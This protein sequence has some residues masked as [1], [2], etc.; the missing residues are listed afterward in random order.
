MAK[1]GTIRFRRDPS[2]QGDE[3]YHL[4]VTSAGIN[5]SASTDIGLFYGATT[6]WQLIAGSTDG[7]IGAVSIDDAPAFAWRGVMLDSARHFQP[8]AYIKQLIDRMAMDKLN[9]LHWH[10]TDDQAW[11]IPID[12]YPRLI[13]VGAWRQPAGAAGFDASGKPVRY[14]GFYT[15]AEIRDIVAYAA[16]RHITVVPE[17]EM[18]GHATAAI[19]AYPRLGSTATPPTTPTS[20]WGVMY[21]LYNTDDATFAFL[22]DVLD[23][24]LEL[25]PSRYI[26]VGGDEAVKDQWIADPRA[27]ARMKT[28]GITDY[29]QL[30]GWYIARIGD[31]LAKRGRKLVGWD[32]ILD[33]KVPPSATV[34]SWRGID[35]AIKAAKAGHDAILAPS[36]DFYIDHIQSESD[37][38]PPGR[39]GVMDWKHI[40]TFDVAPAALTAME[41]KY[42][43]GV[44]VNL[45]TEH[46]RTT[47][48]ADRML[49]PRAA[50]LAELG[51]TPTRRRD[52]S[53]FAA[54]LPAEFARY[55][56]LGFAYNMTPLEP[57]ASF[58]AEDGKL[59]VKLRQPAGVGMLRYTTDGTTPVATSPAYDG[60][61]T[62]NEGTKLRVRAFAGAAALG[63]GRDWTMATALIRTRRAGEMDLCT[64]A[65]SL[66]L[67]DDGATEG[68]RRVHWGDIFHPC[69][70]WKQAKL[71]GIASLS[72][73]VGQVPFNFSIGADL[74][75]V[76]FDKPRTPG[77]EL[78]VRLDSCTGPVVVSIPLGAATRNSGVSTIAGALPQRTG[79][80]DLCMT[81]TQSGPDPLWMLDRLTLVPAR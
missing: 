53:G 65:V 52:W 7:R 61:L 43:T 13:S 14:G 15:K 64:S 80:H 36:P 24:V 25:F 6:L 33:G 5:I 18:P 59:T 26:H 69:W 48:Y 8:A 58:D 1:S 75:K 4:R 45:W 79:R 23:E 21:N 2:I 19:A 71:D 60:K 67:E 12:K 20:S 81:F 70:I 73:E 28:L 49:W 31:Y 51:W 66:R 77:G 30:Q 50:A 63:M 42:L 9:V 38:E 74:A 40:Y 16:A 3:A 29:E 22:A 35:G 27:A 68:V 34:M 47:A 56:R 37:D 62:L 39:G 54:R 55:R 72:A 57:L 76:V 32:E 78:E 17:I 46:V 11:R 10:L 44:Q 41:R